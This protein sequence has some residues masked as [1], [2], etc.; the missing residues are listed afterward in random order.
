MWPFE[1]ARGPVP[2]SR[3]WLQNAGPKRGELKEYNDM[4]VFM[5]YTVTVQ[6]HRGL[7]SDYPNTVLEVPDQETLLA[8]VAVLRFS[9]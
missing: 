7:Y 6:T 8:D 4:G 9:W 2:L 1:S 3:Q 5:D